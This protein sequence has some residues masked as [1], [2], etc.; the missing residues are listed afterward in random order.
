M[1]LSELL[2]R[3]Y[4]PKLIPARR[5]QIEGHGRSFP[6]FAV[7]LDDAA[8]TLYDAICGSQAESRSPAPFLC[9]EE[10]LEHPALGIG[11]HADP[12]VLSVTETL[13]KAPDFIR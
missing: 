9:G 4:L 10:R 7:D 8:V 6:D 11:I 12:I 3:L 1:S 2:A 5:R 13:T